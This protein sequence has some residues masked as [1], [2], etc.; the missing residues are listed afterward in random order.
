MGLEIA[1][2]GS[3]GSVSAHRRISK[4]EPP[5]Q[6]SASHLG[7]NAEIGRLSIRRRGGQRWTQ[8][9]GGEPQTPRL[10][11]RSGFDTYL[12]MTVFPHRLLGIRRHRCRWRAAQLRPDIY[13][14]RGSA[15]LSGG[16]ASPE[17]RA[18]RGSLRMCTHSSGT[19]TPNLNPNY[20][21][22]RVANIVK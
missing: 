10:A 21:L 4:E 18:L 7:L 19:L 1:G 9:G 17:F 13:P 11:A 2:S 14:N 15:A 12:L 22:L 20:E 3:A 16:A 5:G 6:W 8:T